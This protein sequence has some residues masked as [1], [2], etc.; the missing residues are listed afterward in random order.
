VIVAVLS[1]CEEPACEALTIGRYCIRHDASSLTIAARQRRHRWDRA[2][3]E[4]RPAEPEP[5][6]EPV[7]AS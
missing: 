4:H 7:A 1:T 2:A 5:E 6:P 3:G